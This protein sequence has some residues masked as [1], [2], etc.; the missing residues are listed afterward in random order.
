[1]FVILFLWCLRGYVGSVSSRQPL[2]KMLTDFLWSVVNIIGL[3]FSTFFNPTQQLPK[4]TSHISGSTRSS[5]PG[6]QSG[7]GRGG[8]GPKGA[9]VRGMDVIRRN[10]ANCAG[11]G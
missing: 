2:Y 5:A 6:F 7:V 3:L 9:N 1:M 4:K 8:G 11:G 10:A